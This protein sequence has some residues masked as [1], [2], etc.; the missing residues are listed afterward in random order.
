MVIKR[1][2]VRDQI[3]DL[4]LERIINGYYKP[5]ERLVELRIAEELSTSQAPV[6]E[7]FRYLE[8]L[9]VVE[10]EPYK[11]TRV[12]EITEREMR[13]SS[14][15]RVALEQLGAELAETKLTNNVK[16][17]KGEAKKFMAAAKR[18]DVAAYAEHD[19]EFHRLII[20]SSGNQV[21]LS[22]WESVVLESRFRITLSTIGPDKLLE[23]G[24]EHMPIIDCFEK[25]DGQGAG[26]R[27]RKLI[28]KFHGLTLQV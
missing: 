24:Q 9:R 14:E 26:K 18:K 8:A 27:L 10:T 12:R 17:L 5:G 4:L 6:R 16:E 20:Q 25:G 28:C 2:S 21:L 19:T 11:G 3:K 13:E 7:A 15:V 22:N 1:S 23:F